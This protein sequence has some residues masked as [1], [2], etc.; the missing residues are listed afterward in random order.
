[1][2]VKQ[3]PVSA[4]EVEV[5]DK[6]SQGNCVRSD[7]QKKNPIAQKYAKALTNI[8]RSYTKL[9]QALKF[10]HQGALVKVNFQQKRY[11]F[12]LTEKTF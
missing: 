6:V 2:R 1:M 3:L 9:E 7:V 5:L 10:Q 4:T 11:K 8:P 12:C